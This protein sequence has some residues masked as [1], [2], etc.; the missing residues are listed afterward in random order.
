MHDETANANGV[1]SIYHAQRTVA[2]Q[3]A[4]S[5]LPCCVNQR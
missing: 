1:G 2:E 3:G 4:A 5:P